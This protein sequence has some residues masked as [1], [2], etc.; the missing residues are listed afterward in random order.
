MF[1]KLRNRFLIL[2]LTIISVMMLLSFT[3]IYLVTL[4]NVNR[5]I[6]QELMKVAQVSRKADQ[7]PNQ[8]SN[9]AP[10]QLP[11]HN[12]DDKLKQGHSV[13]FAVVVDNNGN[14][15]E[16]LSN[17]DKT[18]SFY[19]QAKTL[20]LS[21]KSEKG[22]FKLEDNYWTYIIIDHN[23]I[24]KIIFLDTSPEHGI[25]SNLIIT[26]SVA[27]V[28]MLI[29]IFFVSRFFAD[30]SI[31]PVKEAFDKQK[32]FVADASHELK[33]PLT[34]INTN[35]DVLLSNAEDETNSKWLHYIKSE[36]ERMAKLTN[37][38]LYLTKVDYSETKL[39]STVFNLSDTVENVILTMEA[40]IFEHN[41]TFDYNIEPNLNAH[42]NSEQLQQVVLIL[43]D[44]ALKYTNK[45]G[46]IDVALKKSHNNIVFKITNT[47][48]GI[49]KEHLDKI[50][51]R[52]YR[53]DKSRARESGGYG[54]GLSIAKAIIEQH[55]GKIYAT[56]IENEST[57]FSFELPVSVN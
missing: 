8:P 15:K 46:R 16:T 28:I 3:T 48:E 52:F 30:K 54:L 11:Q 38:L 32:Q 25:L 24:K 2:N 29:V 21:Q 50:F 37:D 43:L 42:G 12:E 19:E 44:N 9:Q 4:S 49:A 14:K 34:V 27:A 36:A 41:I 40:A 7:P 55:K 35:V 47:G 22:T 18:D 20:A 51:D 33:T 13:S 31:K 23:D 5:N 10:N 1:K 56:S 57:T 6:D 53:T 39:V 45:K 17:L 26:F